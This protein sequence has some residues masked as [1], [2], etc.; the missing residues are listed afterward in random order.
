MIFRAERTKNGF[1]LSPPCLPVSLLNFMGGRLG[2]GGA[3]DDGRCRKVFLRPTYF[4][5]IRSP[6]P[7]P[8]RSPV[9]EMSEG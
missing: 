2:R 4:L 5:E 8:R 7:G 6:L 1:S 3:Y 9:I